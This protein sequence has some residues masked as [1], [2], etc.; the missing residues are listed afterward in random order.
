MGEASQGRALDELGHQQRVAVLLA[1]LVES[2]DAGVVQPRRRLGLA[3]HPPAGLAPLLDRLHR[4]RSFE[5][6]VPSLVDDAEAAAAD[7]TLDQ[8][9][10]EY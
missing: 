1:E 5:A 10:V 6:A 9:P 2:D 8:E 7:A 3:Q 4:H